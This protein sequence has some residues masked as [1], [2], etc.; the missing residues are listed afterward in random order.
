MSQTQS[1]KTMSLSLSLS[2]SLLK[3]PH[4]KQNQS[5]KFNMNIRKKKKSSDRREVQKR[6]M[7]FPCNPRN[8]SEAEDEKE[9]KEEQETQIKQRREAKLTALMMTAQLRLETPSLQKLRNETLENGKHTRT[10]HKRKQKNE[11]T[12]T[13][14]LTHSLT[15]ITHSSCARWLA[16]V[17]LIRCCDFHTENGQN[18]KLGLRL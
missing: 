15:Q 2:L 8:P 10:Q 7:I 4:L 14:S 3:I 11:R 12:H 17:T 13:H 6:A 5:N 18:P 16:G 1:E 9:N